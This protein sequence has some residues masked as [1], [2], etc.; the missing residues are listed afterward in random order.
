MHSYSRSMRWPEVRRDP[1]SSMHLL[2][3]YLALQNRANI[4]ARDLE[5]INAAADQLNQEADDALRYQAPVEYEE[6]EDS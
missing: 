5:L 1:N 4:N 2:K 6:E 3:E